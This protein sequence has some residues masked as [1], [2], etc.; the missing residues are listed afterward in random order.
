MKRTARHPETHARLLAATCGFAIALAVGGTLA[1]TAGAFSAPRMSEA[2]STDLP[3]FRTSLFAGS[4]DCA[5]CHTSDGEVLRDSQGNDL[6][7]PEDWRATMMA[8][9]FRD[10]FFQATLERE[11]AL[12][13]HR[14]GEIEDMCLRCHAPM[15]HTQAH[16]D[17]TGPL[18]LAHA[19][20]S[21]LAAEGVSCTVCHQ[22]Q[23]DNLF[24]EESWDGNYIIRDSAEI[25]GPYEG[26]YQ[27]AMI[28]ALGYTP[29]FGAH[30]L[31]S[32]HCATCHTLFTPIVDEAGKTLGRFPEQTPYLEWRNSIYA[33]AAN[34]VSC[35]DCHMPVIDDPVYISHD[36]PVT[37]RSPF[38]KHHFVGG[39]TFMLSLMRDNIERLGVTAEER[40]F[41]MT[42]ERTRRQLREDTATL[43]VVATELEPDHATVVVRV[44]N[45]TGHKLPTGYPARRAWLRFVARDGDGNALFESGAWDNSGDIHGVGEDWQPHRDLIADPAHVQVYEGIMA[46]LQ[47]RRTTSLLSAASYLKDNRLP[48]RGFRAD[49]PYY[50][51][52]AI[53]GDAAT[54]ANFNRE[55]GVEGSGS[56]R[57]AYRFPLSGHPP[58]TIRIEVELLYQ[59]IIPLFARNLAE[60][61]TPGG[62]DFL[63]L[64][65]QRHNQPEWV[66][67]VERLL[68]ARPS[69]WTIY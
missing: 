29:K 68:V 59:S 53:I 35:Q 10:P 4:G 13:P 12:R 61:D 26:V 45:L 25:F 20:L 66:A 39:N 7:M 46:D 41:D 6:S 43:A 54:D 50:A 8:N 11:V 65:A 5:F 36:P 28:S 23:P 34:A 27:W 37:E 14:Q 52:T 47:G 64:Y 67:R 42:I 32:E 57:V 3:S 31:T 19:R 38:W 22:I 17:G 24:G 63:E 1:H 18:S 30:M 49:G 2:H 58:E 21:P 51:D 55:A 16:Y 40:H 48:P 33:D 56:D 69:A 44:E 60:P 62:L 15:A 9:S